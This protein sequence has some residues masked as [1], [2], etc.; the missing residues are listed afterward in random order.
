MLQQDEIDCILSSRTSSENDAMIRVK[1]QVIIVCRSEAQPSQFL[2]QMG[3]ISTSI[4]EYRVLL[5]GLP[6]LSC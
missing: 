1:N 3:G 4:G 2:T 5:L 6:S